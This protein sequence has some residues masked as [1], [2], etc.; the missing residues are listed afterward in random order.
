MSLDLSRLSAPDAVAALRS[1]PRRYRSALAALTP[2]DDVDALARRVGPTGSSAFDLTV[3]TVRTLAIL[4]Q[5]LHQVLTVD[6]PVLHEAVTNPAARAWDGPEPAGLGDALDL[7]TD[8]ANALADT[9]DRTSF[10]QWSRP[11]TVAGGGTLEAFDIV[12]EAVRTGGD[13][14]RAAEQA[15][16]A[17]RR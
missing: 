2:D 3:D 16:A 10:T 8:E 11:A 1:Y 5:A 4:G 14:L 9:I 7:L 6:G 15:M 12:R 17:A 13:N